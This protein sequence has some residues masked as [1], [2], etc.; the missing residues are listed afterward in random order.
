M[1]QHD[2][3]TGLLLPSAV[4][5]ERVSAPTTERGYAVESNGFWTTL[6]DEKVPELQWPD[7]IGIYDQMRRTDA[8]VI[9]VLRAMQLPIRRTPARLD[10]T[11][12]PDEVVAFVAANLGLPVKGQEPKQLPR[13]RDRFS[14]S[15]HLRHALTCLPFGH[16]FFEQT[17]R[18]APDERG[19]LRAWLRKLGWRPP[20]TITRIDVAPDGGLIAIEQGVAGTKAHRMEVSVLVAYVNERE[21]GN[22]LGQSLLR[23]AY[24]YWVLKDRML[25]VQAQ[26]VDRNGMGVPVVT[27]P[28]IPKDVYDQTEHARRQDQEIARGLKIARSLRAGREA[29]ASIAHS[30]DIKLLGVEGTLPDADKPI[31]YYDEQISRSVLAH[32]LNLGTETGS[33]ALGS[34][35]ADFF[36]LSLQSV[37]DSIADTASMHVVEDLVDINFGTDVPAPRIVFDQIGQRVTA[38]DIK[39][40][41]NS[42]G[43]RTDDDLEAFLRQAFGLPAKRAGEQ[44]V[45]GGAGSNTTE[46]K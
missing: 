15:E 7:N 10:P 24:K 34:T 2:S 23:P 46:E 19:V 31:R 5:R 1:F 26:T 20:R 14:W 28:E 40:L 11:G 29:G 33:W 32:F 37:A 17:Y 27:A 44:N 36:T 6:D 45:F 35:F 16:S 12:V 13:M 39:K 21:G 25:R 22:W 3:H 41:L 8:Q 9:S 18:I 4:A 38:D 30:A 42:G 43:I